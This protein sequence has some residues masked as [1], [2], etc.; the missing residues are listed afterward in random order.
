MIIVSP[1]FPPQASR[2]LFSSYPKEWSDSADIRDNANI[3]TMTYSL[4]VVARYRDRIRLTRAAPARYC[5]GRART[6]ATSPARQVRSR[7]YPCDYF[8]VTRFDMID[9][10]FLRFIDVA[11]SRAGTCQRFPGSARWRTTNNLG[12]L[13][14]ARSPSD[15]RTSP[16]RSVRGKSANYP[17]GTFRKI[18]PSLFLRPFSYR[19]YFNYTEREW[20]VNYCFISLYIVIIFR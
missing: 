18:G 20:N 7:T 4:V 8:R 13:S 1:L 5:R 2:F 3:A 10:S 14:R 9:E 6:R 19:D 11:S 16:V 12:Y 15:R 17:W